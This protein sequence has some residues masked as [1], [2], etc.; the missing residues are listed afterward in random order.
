MNVAQIQ[1]VAVAPIL[2]HLAPI[3]TH[4]LAKPIGLGCKRPSYCF[5]M[6][7]IPIWIGVQLA[8]LVR[9]TSP[10]TTANGL[11]PGSVR[12]REEEKE[13][14]GKRKMG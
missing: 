3:I 1:A 13:G 6:F 7:H 10:I 11:R 4:T 12:R 9:L 2:V 5:A 8:D 14:E